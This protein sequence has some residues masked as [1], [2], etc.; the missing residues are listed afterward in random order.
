MNDGSKSTTGE[1]QFMVLESSYKWTCLSYIVFRHYFY[2][3]LRICLKIISFHAHLISVVS[4]RM[5]S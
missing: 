2:L 1:L 3:L 5:T 4:G